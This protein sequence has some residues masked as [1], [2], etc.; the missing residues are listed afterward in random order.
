[1]NLMK[2][3]ETFGQ[4]ITRMRYIKGLTQRKLA[5]ISGISNTTISRI[6]KGETTKPDLPTLKVLAQH[7]GVDEFDMIQASGSIPHDKPLVVDNHSTPIYNS[8]AASERYYAPIQAW[9]STPASPASSSQAEDVSPLKGVR[10]ITL[11][12]KRNITQRELGEMLGIEK[13]TIM[14]YENQIAKP[15]LQMLQRIAET[16]HVSIDYLV[17]KTDN[18]N[19]VA[20]RQ[21]SALIAAAPEMPLEPVKIKQEY[22]DIAR[23]LQSHNIHPDD[24]RTMMNLM[25]KY[26]SH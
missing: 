19:D 16:F 9:E 23:E 26:K 13:T 7:L 2:D 6:E 10:L 8:N 20:W 17:G 22:L 25:L 14:Q 4:Y 15:N 24:I 21:K 12:L 18:P 5:Q 11:R 3:N 1:M